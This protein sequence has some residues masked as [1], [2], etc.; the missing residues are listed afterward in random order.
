MLY[1][2]QGQWVYHWK[3]SHVHHGKKL[4]PLAWCLLLFLVFAALLLMFGVIKD[5]EKEANPNERMGE[6]PIRKYIQP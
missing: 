5:N 6:K 1:H 4:L 3:H 2:L